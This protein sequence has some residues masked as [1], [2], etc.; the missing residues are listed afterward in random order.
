MSL[1]FYT[2]KE[3]ENTF[4]ECFNLNKVIRSIAGTETGKLIILLDDMYESSRDVQ[5]PNLK[6]NKI[7][8]KRIRETMQSQILLEGD[9]ITRFNNLN[10]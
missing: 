10:N 2:R 4:T 5:A 9:D 7:E 6:T 1:F 8:V 3:G